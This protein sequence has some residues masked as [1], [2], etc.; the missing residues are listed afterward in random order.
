[1]PQTAASLD[2]RNRAL[3]TLT[4]NFRDV[5]WLVCAAQ[6]SPFPS[7]ETGNYRPRWRTDAHEAGEV[8]TVFESTQAQHKAIDLALD[9]P[10]HDERTLGDLVER[11]EALS[12]ERR[13]RVWDHISTWNETSPD[14]SQKATLREAIRRCALTRRSRRR[15]L[16]EALR[17]RAR[18]AYALLEPEDPVVRHGWLFLRQWVDESADE[19]EDE[20]LDYDKRVERIAHQRRRALRD[21]WNQAGLKGIKELCRSGDAPAAVGWHMAEIITDVEAAANL[22]QELLLDQS[23]ELR[24]K[25]EHCIGGFLGKLGQ[26]ERRS[27]VSEAINRLGRHNIQADDLGIRLLRCAPF[28]GETWQ[29]VDKLPKNLRRRYWK[30]VHARWGRHDAS[31]MAR[32]VDELLK[33]DR[34]R[35]AFHAAHMDWKLLDTAHLV[36]LLTEVATN[37]SEPSGYYRLEAYDISK[38]LDALEERGDTS[39]DELARLEFMF[40]EALDHT[41]HGIRNL[42]AQLS[43]TPTLFMQALALAFNRRDDGEDPPE[44]RV[45]LVQRMSAFGRKRTFSNL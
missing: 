23:D 10:A 11:L 33:V 14:D 28:D 39:R 15:N 24:D 41:K 45:F 31:E 22:L 20:D 34:P 43:E 7:V 16:D 42:E 29:H 9:W 13:N 18:K 1:M 26:E 4:R 37:E 3:E 2:Q 27:V 21:V 30:E 6:F 19:I 25:L 40:V 32:L 12:P 36:R 38:A 17:D 35:A 5:G 8:A 44:W